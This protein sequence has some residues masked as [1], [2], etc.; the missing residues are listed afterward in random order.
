MNLSSRQEAAKELES[1]YSLSHRVLVKGELKSM[2]M[3]MSENQ[4]SW[5][6]VHVTAILLVG[7]D[8][9]TLRIQIQY[10]TSQVKEGG[11]QFSL[12]D[13]SCDKETD[14]QQDT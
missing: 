3:M 12:M 6:Q 13:W 5:T 10:A 11:G 7:T 9:T 4:L 8:Q 14:G 2:R 1:T